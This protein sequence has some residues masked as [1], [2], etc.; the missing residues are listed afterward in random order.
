MNIRQKG[1]PLA[2]ASTLALAA[3]GGPVHRATSPAHGAI[4]PKVSMSLLEG[5]RTLRADMVTNGGQADKPTLARISQHMDTG[6]SS[7]TADEAAWQLGQDAGSAEKDVGNGDLWWVD[8][9]TL[10]GDCR[11]TG[12]RIPTLS[13]P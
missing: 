13:S 10:A 12:V 3:C 6:G 8:A 7:V 4:S 2:L 11:S 9:A 1:L 5:C